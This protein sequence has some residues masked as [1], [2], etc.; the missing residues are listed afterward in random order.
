MKNEHISQNEKSFQKDI[1]KYDNSCKM[2]ANKG[3]KIRIGQT[4]L[5]DS[6]Y[7]I[8]GE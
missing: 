2:P 5:M 8:L 3:S 7:V 6:S 1:D 4:N